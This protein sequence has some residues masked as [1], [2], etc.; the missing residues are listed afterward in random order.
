R[1]RPGARLD[2]SVKVASWPMARLEPSLRSPGATPGARAR[3]TTA[4]TLRTSKQIFLERGLGGTRIEHITEACGISRSGFYT[5]FPTKRDVLLA[6][7]A[8]T[9]DAVDECIAE[10]ERI[11]AP[12]REALERWV[13]HYFDL[14]DEHGAFIL[15]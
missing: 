2:D 1:L 8:T 12:T 7:G 3:R 5:Y 10:L 13:H 15:V 11:E 9:N 6:I 14:L 4:L